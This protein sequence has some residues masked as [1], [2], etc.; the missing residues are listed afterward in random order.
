MTSPSPAKSVTTK[1][2]SGLEIHHY[3]AG[4]GDAVVFLHGGGPGASGLSNYQGNYQYFTDRGY[5]ALMPDLVGWGQSS[6]P[7]G[8]PYDYDLL[9]GSLISWLEE[10]GIDRV[11]VVGNSLGGAVAIYMALTKPELVGNLILLAPAGIAEPEV[12]APMPG[13]ATLFKIATGERPLKPSALRELFEMMYHDP[14]GIDDKV[15]EERAAVANTQPDDLFARLDLPTHKDRLG[16]IRCPVLMLWGAA[17]KFCPLETSRNIL[18]A[19]ENSRLV[20]FASCGHW[21]QV[22]KPGLFNRLTLDFLQNG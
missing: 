11:S 7:S 22:E 5:R 13:I 8:V 21:V 4:E 9:A 15:V 14:A 12:Y 20:A 16:G 2:D 10:L 3:E 6:K 18:D 17:D 1:L 19:C